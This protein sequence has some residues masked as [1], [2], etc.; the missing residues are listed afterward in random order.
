MAIDLGFRPKAG[1]V[2]TPARP[3]LQ[4]EREIEE[5]QS[6]DPSFRDLISFS[7]EQDFISSSIMNRAAMNGFDVD[8]DFVWSEDEWKNATTDL[9]PE[10]HDRL[11]VATSRDHALAIHDRIKTELDLEQRLGDAGWEGFGAR[12]LANAADP[13]AMAVS[14]AAGPMGWLRRGTR[15]QRAIKGGLSAGGANA[16]IEAVVSQGQL[17]RDSSDVLY[18]GLAGLALGAPLNMLG[19]G[20]QRSFSRS[21]ENIAR[22]QDQAEL[23]DVADSVGAARVRAFSAPLVEEGDVVARLGDPEF[24]T[25]TSA[26]GTFRLDPVGQLGQSEDEL[27]RSFGRQLGEEGVGLS[28]KNVKLGFAASEKAT[29]IY[30]TSTVAWRTISEPALLAWSRARGRSWH[31]AQYDAANRA[32]FFTDVGETMRGRK[33]SDAEV[34]RTAGRMSET[35]AEY[36][37]KLKRAR[38]KGFEDVEFNANYLPRILAHDK[39]RALSATFGDDSFIR[40]IAKS[41]RAHSPDIDDDVLKA[42]SRGYWVRLNRLST[43]LDTGIIHGFSTEDTA[44]VREMLSEAGMDVDAVD[45]VVGSMKRNNEK[46]GV[47]SRA[48]RRV[49]LDETASEVMVAADGSTREVNIMELFENNAEK[50]VTHYARQMSGLIGLAEQANIRSHA[51][52][53]EVVRVIKSRG[54]ER[55]RDKNAVKKDT[56]NLE[57]LYNGIRGVPLESDPASTFANAGRLIR[58]YNF[59]LYMNQVGAAQVA[60]LGTSIGLAGLN[61]MLVHIPELRGMLTRAKNGQLDDQFARELEQTLGFGTDRLNNQITTRFDEHGLGFTGKILGKVDNTLQVTKRLT[62]DFSGMAP[63]N[64]VL[65][66][67]AAK[68]AA[69]RVAGWALNSKPLSKAKM[70]RLKSMG[71]DEKDLAD[72]REQLK[73]HSKLTPSILVKGGKIREL[74]PDK[75]DTAV[76]NKFSLALH[77]QGRRMVQEND[78]GTLPI[79]MHSTLGKLLFQF[80]SFMMGAWVK[81]TLHN[82]HHKD[83][84]SFATVS[85]SM[86][87]GT[88][89]YI[90]QTVVNH[91]NNEE[92]RRR[93]LEPKR[94]AAAAF[95]R[96]G[97]SSL[98]PGMVDTFYGRISTEDPFFQ[99]SRSSGLASGFFAGNPSV[100]T[101]DKAIEVLGLG[102]VFRD[103]YQFSRKDYEN[104]TG[105]IPFVSNG[106][107]FRN[108]HNAI[109]ET[110]PRESTENF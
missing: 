34:N 5:V 18:A 59:S 29:L 10:L 46:R 77:R 105:L 52:F 42:L 72:I 16:A 28:D 108:V 100:A 19:K 2:T 109:T 14:L 84:Q 15:L 91:A 65:Q 76:L 43:G 79:F 30:R 45:N 99:F 69:Q 70:Q 49:D 39:I 13:V 98:I 35:L 104:L 106:I 61:N 81:Q 78:I 86:F 102:R 88:L 74:N 95:L 37:G 25:P 60:E 94:I 48:K 11:A 38:V 40:L 1:S 67:I 71:L 89:A 20:D 9:P 27:V 73:A 53:E 58:D 7:I 3:S 6:A 33:S 87:F 93:M 66:R 51:D 55:G 24:D 57:H 62:A 103:D 36:L 12:L 31:N 22:A 92:A 32:E 80:R 83:F 63:I 54:K 75:W 96:A 56:K 101:A 82:L 41:I 50:L 110:L 97:A 90:A 47:T 107:A 85:L 44:F 64:I 4:Q 26:A 8:P 21:V 17:T 68:T 23:D